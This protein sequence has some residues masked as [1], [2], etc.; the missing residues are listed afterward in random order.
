MPLSAA[1]HFFSPFLSKKK[2]HNNYFLPSLT[3][4]FLLILLYFSFYLSSIY[5]FSNQFRI[6]LRTI[7]VILLYNLNITKNK[8]VVFY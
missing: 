8:N 6:D 1:F 5:I 7:F 2:Y 3:F 4:L